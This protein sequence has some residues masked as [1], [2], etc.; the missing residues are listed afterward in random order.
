MTNLVAS[1]PTA[2]GGAVP[3]APPNKAL[4]VG[5]PL[6]LLAVVV[7]AVL[8]GNGIFILGFLGFVV[9]LL[10]SVSLHEG[11]HFLTARRFGMK[12][13]QF[14][15]GFGPTIWSRQRGETEWGVKAIPAG[16]YVKIVGMTSLEEVE[17]GDEDRVFWKQPWKQRLVVLAAGSTVHFIIAVTLVLLSALSIGRVDILAPAVGSVAECV[18]RLATSDCEDTGALPAHAQA[19]GLQAGD[20]VVEVDGS[21]VEDTDDF[22]ELVRGAPGRALPLVVDREGQRVSLTVTPVEVSRP[23]LPL[24]DE[25]GSYVVRDDKL[26][27]GPDEQ[28]GAIGIAIEERRGTERLGPVEAVGHSVDQ[29]QLIVTG[30]WTTFSE[31]LGTIT[32]VYGPERDPAGFIG[33]YG[34][35]RLS[36]EVLASDETLAF[37][38]LG[39]LSLIA[40]LNFFVGVFNLLPLLPLDGGHIAVLAFEQARDKLKRMRGYSGELVRVDLTKLLPLTYGVVLFFAAF[41]IWLLGADIVNPVRLPQ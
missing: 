30:I 4:L 10:V 27:F 35:G 21:A 6:F 8:Q 9:A 19:A 40:G 26:V 32:K 5:I 24:R 1:R 36:G 29:M 20:V 15:V 25:D 16:G 39:F 7:V 41:T 38:L 28:V 18:P 11:G 22:L 33:I 34:A 12:A 37:K 23:G 3:P 14:F 2:D 31:K 13:T 17:P